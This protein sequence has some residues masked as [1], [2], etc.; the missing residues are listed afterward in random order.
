MNQNEKIRIIAVLLSIVLCG[1]IFTPAFATTSSSGVVIQSGSG[2]SPVREISHPIAYHALFQTDQ[3][4]SIATGSHSISGESVDSASYTYELLYD[5]SKNRYSAVVE[6]DFLI[7][8]QSYS[9]NVSGNV[10]QVP[11]GQGDVFLSGP[12]S[13]ALIGKDG[14][15]VIVGY[16]QIMGKEQVSLYVTFLTEDCQVVAWFGD[17]IFTSDQ[18]D[19]LIDKATAPSPT[20]PMGNNA[21]INSTQATSEYTLI[22]DVTASMPPLASLYGLTGD[23]HTCS[24]YFKPG[25]SS[26]NQSNNLIVGVTSY[27]DELAA[28]ATSSAYATNVQA[29]E[30]TLRATSTSTTIPRVTQYVNYDDLVPN[31]ET[32]VVVGYLVEALAIVVDKIP[33]PSAFWVSQALSAYSQFY[34]KSPA[35]YPQLYSTG[36]TLAKMKTSFGICNG[37]DFDDGPFFI[38]MQLTGNKGRADFNY[39][40]DT[41]IQYG[42]LN[43]GGYCYHYGET[44]QLPFEVAYRDIWA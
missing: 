36:T 11:L 37:A 12:L 17:D 6:I 27:C 31:Q 19:I 10:D 13:G 18:L 24:V 5:Q 2:E 1:N 15:E 3:E 35:I 39:I 38:Q 40:V 43:D 41:R 21:N 23:A 28:N 29:I 16:N 34:D 4:N 33:H 20:V 30:M 7:Q 26:S 42:R 14:C 9:A 25:T 32:I 22:D 8:D 44:A